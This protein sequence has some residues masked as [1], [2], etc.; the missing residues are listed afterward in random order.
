MIGKDSKVNYS[1]ADHLRELR[2][3]AGLSQQRIADILGVNR[4]TYSYWENGQVTIPSDKAYTLAHYYDCSI[5]YLFGLSPYKTVDAAA[6]SEVTGLSDSAIRTLKYAM[7]S[8]TTALTVSN[9]LE[10]YKRNGAS[11]VLCLIGDF[12]SAQEGDIVETKPTVGFKAP[13][14]PVS[15]KIDLSAALLLSLNSAMERFRRE[16]WAK[17]GD[18]E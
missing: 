10:D 1:G 6:I 4:M 8:P 16:H 7:L 9:I 14:L 2:E 12:L 11:S 5:D 17:P 3:E 15:Y 18:K 13:L